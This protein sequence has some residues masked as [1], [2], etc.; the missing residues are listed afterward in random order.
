[1]VIEKTLT[2]LFYTLNKHLIQL[3]SCKGFWGIEAEMCIPNISNE[4]GVI[5]EFTASENLGKRQL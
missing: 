2:L 1:M 3:L 4:E 5:R